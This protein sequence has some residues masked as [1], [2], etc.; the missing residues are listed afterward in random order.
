[1]QEVNIFI[2]DDHNI[3]AQ[4]IASLLKQ[5]NQVAQVTIFKNGQE[6]FNHCAAQIPDIVF[7]DLEMPVWDGRKT[8]VEIKKKLS[9]YF[10]L[11]VIHSQ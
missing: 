4:G 10:V 11:Y 9:H 8:L 5:T 2:A 1:M 3:V 7:L 6:L